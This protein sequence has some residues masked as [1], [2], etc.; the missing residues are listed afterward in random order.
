MKSMYAYQSPPGL[1]RRWII[2]ERE[3]TG[4]QQ[5]VDIKGRKPLPSFHTRLYGILMVVTVIDPFFYPAGDPMGI[6]FV[7]NLSGG[8]FIGVKS[9]QPSFFFNGQSLP[10]VVVDDA[11]QNRV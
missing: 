8:Y 1:S 10:L 9:D 11:I 4:S 3:T 5:L 7:Q 2:I 6:V